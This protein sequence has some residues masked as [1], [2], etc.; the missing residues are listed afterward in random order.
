[1]NQCRWIAALICAIPWLTGPTV[2]Q[3]D[4]GIE[5]QDRVEYV[6]LDGVNDTPADVTRLGR[7]LR[8][9]PAKLNLIPF[10]PV[11]GWLRYRPPSQRRVIVFRDRLL[12][13][14]LRVS[15]RWSRGTE[16]RAACGQLA[17]L[18]ERAGAR[19]TEE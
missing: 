10:N 2:A 6:L 13:M 3:R 11:P 5:E 19:R 8:R 18:P 14:G 1:M 12:D 17:L 9:T 7:I 15:I 16:A 4:A